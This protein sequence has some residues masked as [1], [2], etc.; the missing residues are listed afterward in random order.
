MKPVIYTAIGFLIAFSAAGQDSSQFE[1]RKIIEVSATDLAVDN[2]GNLFVFTPTG[3][4]KKLSPNGDSI[5]VYNDVRRYGKLYSVD[6]SNPLKVLLYYRDYGTVVVLDR[7]LNMRNS[8]DLRKLNLLQVKAIGQ[9]YD[10]GIWV[11]D[12]LEGKIKHI[13]DDGRVTDQSTDFRQMFDSMPS[14]EYIVDQSRSLY[15]YDPQK[16][17]YIF[18]YYGSFRSRIP[19]LGWHDFTVIG[20]TLFGREDDRFFRYAPGSLQVQELRIPAYMQ[21]A[22]SIRITPGALYVLRQQRL[23]IYSYRSP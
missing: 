14:P 7:L 16:G 12:E 22:L 15:L 19:L 8:I 17:V 9:A 23:E 21:N 6:V 18:D 10:N 13:G 20:N 4:L 5:A 1:L 2:L 11:F 3:Q